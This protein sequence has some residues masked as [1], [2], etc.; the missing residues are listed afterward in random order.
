MKSEQLRLLLSRSGSRSLFIVIAIA[1][2][3]STALVISLATI[4]SQIVVSLVEGELDV[5]P[6]IA[7]LFSLWVFRAFFQSQYEYWCTR[8][9]I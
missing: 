7:A 9:A 3:I 5:L 8:K 1:S 2:A 4:I 6:K